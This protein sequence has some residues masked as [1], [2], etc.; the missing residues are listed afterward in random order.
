[1]GFTAALAAPVLGYVA[2]A[3]VHQVAAEYRVSKLVA[4][5][6]DL[7]KRR[8][9]MELARASLLS[10]PTVERV[11]REQLD[12]VQEDA[13]EPRSDLPLDAVKPKVT[14]P[15]TAAPIPVSAPVVAPGRHR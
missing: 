8:D 1:M 14:P 4:K 2:L 12:M 7:E 6:Q 3:S 13:A 10:L 5:V 9:R 15:P 11:A